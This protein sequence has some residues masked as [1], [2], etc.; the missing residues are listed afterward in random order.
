MLIL[1]SSTLVPNP[2]HPSI[3]A[4][5]GWLIEHPQISAREL[6]NSDS[7]SE[8]FSTDSDASSEDI[9]E[10]NSFDASAEVA[11]YTVSLLCGMNY[12]CSDVLLIPNRYKEVTTESR[13]SFPRNFS[14]S[15]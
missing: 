9:V 6:N 2:E 15:H 13:N 14:Y 1:G 7:D 4:L 8:D 12:C 5:V 3:E 10:E 11:A